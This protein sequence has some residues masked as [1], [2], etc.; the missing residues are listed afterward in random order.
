MSAIP[1]SIPKMS[2][3]IVDDSRTVRAGLSKILSK[4]YDVSSNKTEYA[5]EIFTLTERSLFSKKSRT[6]EQTFGG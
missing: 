2:I 4:Y 3:L 6:G 1:N 5:G